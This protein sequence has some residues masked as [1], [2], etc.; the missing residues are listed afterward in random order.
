MTLSKIKARLG[1]ISPAKM[2][3]MTK[4]AQRLLEVDM[5][6]LILAVE[7]LQSVLSEEGL[8][9]QLCSYVRGIELLATLA[10]LETG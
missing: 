3:E 1:S 10:A 6:K 8:G 5:P 2:N 9:E 7:A 4:S